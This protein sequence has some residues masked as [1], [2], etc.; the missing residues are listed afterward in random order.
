MF[1][2]KLT[3]RFDSSGMLTFTNLPSESRI[4]LNIY[5]Y[6][7]T[8]QTPNIIETIIQKELRLVKRNKRRNEIKQTKSKMLK[9]MIREKSPACDE[10]HK[11]S[12]KIV[13]CT[14]APSPVTTPF[15][16]LPVWY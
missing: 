16:S 11:C 15:D 2:F 8:G 1:K 13:T 9:R 12:T 5:F 4:H 10:D 3:S 6:N 14:K 7:N